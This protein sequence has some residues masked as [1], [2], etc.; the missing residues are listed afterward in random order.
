MSERKIEI[1]FPFKLSFSLHTSVPGIL[2]MRYRKNAPATNASGSQS[3]SHAESS[4]SAHNNN[5]HDQNNETEQEAGASKNEA[6]RSLDMHIH[7]P[8]SPTIEP[9]SPAPTENAYYYPEETQELASEKLPQ[10]GISSRDF[11]FESSPQGVRKAPEVFDPGLCMLHYRE[12]RGIEAK[13]LRR[14][15]AMGWLSDA[16]GAEQ[17]KPS[18]RRFLDPTVPLYPWK[19]LPRDQPHTTPEE[20]Y[21]AKYK[22]RRRRLKVVGTGPGEFWLVELLDPNGESE[23]S[24]QETIDPSNPPVEPENLYTYDFSTLGEILDWVGKDESETKGGKKRARE[25]QDEEKVPSST[26]DEELTPRSKSK[27]TKRS[28]SVSTSSTVPPQPQPSSTNNTHT[29][30]TRTPT[31]PPDHSLAPTR[32]KP[33]GLARTETLQ[34][35]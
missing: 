28:A 30:A 3:S 24:G 20:E 12:N 27:R 33:R 35:V 7:I 16:E 2:S 17:V 8:P 5:N 19:A 34:H 18:R 25:D 32:R 21:M 4:T 22:Q 31:P 15:R 26:P 11:A 9:P 23:P 29:A 14:L 13:E 1:E 10:L 6:A